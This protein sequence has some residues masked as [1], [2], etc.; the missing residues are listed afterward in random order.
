MRLGH[1]I[2]TMQQSEDNGTERALLMKNSFKDEF[3]ENFGK[4]VTDG[5]LMQISRKLFLTHNVHKK[6]PT[7]NIA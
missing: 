4:E 7:L 2:I 3:D 6:S 1:H 5:Q